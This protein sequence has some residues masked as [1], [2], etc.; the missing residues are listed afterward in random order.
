MPQLMIGATI[1]R[2]L[3]GEDGNGDGNRIGGD[4]DNIP[5]GGVYSPGRRLA[6]R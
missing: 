2:P 3:A 1:A 6:L 4:R 5:L